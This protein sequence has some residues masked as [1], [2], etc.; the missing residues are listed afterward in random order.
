MFSAEHA[1]PD[2]RL[3]P[4][5]H[6]KHTQ[7]PRTLLA[8]VTLLWRAR[9]VRAHRTGCLGRRAS[10]CSISGPGARGPFRSEIEPLP[11][12]VDLR[13]IGPCR[14][15]RLAWLFGS[16][17]DC[18]V[19]AVARRAATCYTAC[20]PGS[21]PAGASV[22]FVQAAVREFTPLRGLAGMRPSFALLVVRVQRGTSCSARPPRAIVEL[23]FVNGSRGRI[24]DSAGRAATT[25]CGGARSARRL[26]RIRRSC[27]GARPARM[28]RGDR[29]RSSS[30][31]RFERVVA[32]G[33]RSAGSVWWRSSGRSGHRAATHRA[34]GL[35]HRRARAC[36]CG[37]D[38]KTAGWRV[39][40]ACPS[41]SR[42]PAV[43]VH[44]NRE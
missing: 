2:D 21:S 8:S 30:R 22:P 32:R 12:G 33:Q 39:F 24:H 34:R 4:R 26:R 27:F 15:V 5:R 41:W 37:S 18:Q 42:R 14:A 31:P 28:Q 17:G 6:N 19:G 16:L 35:R 10:C 13:S 1:E 25:G 7:L 3:L 40:C 44:L 43:L 36:S 29:A 38:E 11:A 9:L 23:R 20:L